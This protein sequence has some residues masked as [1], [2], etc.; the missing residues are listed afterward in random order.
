MGKIRPANSG[1][2]NRSPFY[3]LPSQN[4]IN[5]MLASVG[6]SNF[7]SGNQK[8]LQTR[9]RLFDFEKVRNAKMVETIHK[10]SKISQFG[11]S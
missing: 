1:G 8:Y 3:Q 6:S 10:H 4:E 11:V 9:S 2:A 5:K 7:K